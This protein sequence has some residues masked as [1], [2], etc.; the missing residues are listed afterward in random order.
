MDK[1]KYCKS[2]TAKPIGLKV[3]LRQV[4]ENESQGSEFLTLRSIESLKLPRN[5]PREKFETLCY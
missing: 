2:G 5:Y 1:N 3:K 4:K